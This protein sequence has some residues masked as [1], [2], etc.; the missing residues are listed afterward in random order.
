MYRLFSRSWFAASLIALLVAGSAAF[1]QNDESGIVATGQAEIKAAPD[2]AYVTLAVVTQAAQAA[3]A[4]RENATATTKVINAIVSSG[5]PRENIQTTGYSVSAVMDYK[6]SPP[7]TVGYSVTNQ[8]QVKLTDLT[9]VGALIDTAISAGANSVQGVRFTIEN[10]TRLR[11][12]ALVQAIQNARQKATAMADALG[13]KLGRVTSA[14][15][16][17]GISPPPVMYA[18]RAE[19]AETP[20]LPGEVTVTASVT[21]NYAIL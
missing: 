14:V 18:A 21:L 2:V 17:G 1:A 19:G 11:Q 13:V 6:V 10:E 7:T 20:I 9:K 8:V 4:A 15:E 5:V 3:E 16:S 12:Q